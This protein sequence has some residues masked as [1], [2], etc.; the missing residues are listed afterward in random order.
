MSEATWGRQPGRIMNRKRSATSFG[1]AIDA[2]N[3]QNND[4]GHDSIDPSPSH[5][6]PDILGSAPTESASSN[7]AGERQ[8]SQLSTPAVGVN[9]FQN[10]VK[11]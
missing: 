3:Q 8:P 7:S 11:S 10:R 2:D 5:R 6:V 9:S 1:I 4:D